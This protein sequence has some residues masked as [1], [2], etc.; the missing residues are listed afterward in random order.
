MS[1][2]SPWATIRFVISGIP[3]LL[4]T[5]GQECAWRLILRDSTGS[6]LSATGLWEE[7]FPVTVAPQGFEVEIG[8]STV[9]VRK[10]NVEAGA[11][12]CGDKD[13]TFTNIDSSYKTRQNSTP[14]IPP[15]SQVTDCSAAAAATERSY[16]IDW[17]SDSNI[18][19]SGIEMHQFEILKTARMLNCLES[20]V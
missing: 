16:F 9:T 11:D 13:Y 10:W 18:D 15:L 1:C 6:L 7:L 19:C 4:S 12:F 5:I 20:K 8:Y 14:L 2:I 3:T 17:F